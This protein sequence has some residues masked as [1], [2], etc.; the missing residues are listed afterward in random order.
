MGFSGMLL[1]LFG[2]PVL[3]L[4]CYLLAGITDVADGY[5][6]RKYGW[7]SHTGA[8]L[9]SLADTVFYLIVLLLIALH[10]STA[11]TANWQWI[12]LILA[13]KSGSVLTSLIRF[14]KVVFIHT[15]ANKILGVI[16]FLTVPFVVLALPAIIIK[17][18]FIVAVLPAA[19][20]FMILITAKSPDPNR[21]SIFS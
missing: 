18:V 17:T 3:F 7:T 11:I 12:A 20:E 15:V 16:I 21:K 10:F 2:N 19:E 5:I 9:D 13:I 8:L 1:L 4:T 14:H 6:A